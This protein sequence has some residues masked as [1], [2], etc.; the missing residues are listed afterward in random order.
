VTWDQAAAFCAWD[1][2]RLPTEAE[3]EKA[4]RGS[5]DARIYPW[6]NDPPT[7]A[8]ANVNLLFEDSCQNRL[9]AVGSYPEGVSPYGIHD[10]TGNV[11]EW[12]A[13]WYGMEYYAAS[14]A[15]NPLGPEE[16]EYRLSR[17]GSFIDNIH[18]ELRVSRRKIA[19][20]DSTHFSY[21]FRC[22]RTP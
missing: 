12:V 21:G 22:A 10:M 2:K 13:D 20:P 1:G 3:W 17:G 16:G 5:E 18:E 8:Q 14:P 9:S 19:L 11:S 15:E 7:C 6:G 4:A